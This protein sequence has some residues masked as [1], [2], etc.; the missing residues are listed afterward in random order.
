M[1]ESFFSGHDGWEADVSPN[2]SFMA[3]ASCIN[4]LEFSGSGSK[5]VLL[6]G[7][8][9]SLFGWPWRDILKA[10]EGGYAPSKPPP[11]QIHC[12]QTLTGRGGCLP[13]AEINDISASPV[14]VFLL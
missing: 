10:L 3:A 1:A 7:G 4:S 8:D 9:N 12:P 13:W 14:G 5:A 6:C 11:V 2:M